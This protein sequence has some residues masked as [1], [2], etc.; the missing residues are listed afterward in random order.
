MSTVQQNG[1]VCS[2]YALP[3]RFVTNCAALWHEL[4]IRRWLPNRKAANRMSVFGDNGVTP[5][6]QM[7]DA[8]CWYSTGRLIASVR[9]QLILLRTRKNAG[10]DHGEADCGG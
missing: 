9:L 3:Q 2:V 7:R 4:H 6:E 8:R 5:V 10:S 1:K